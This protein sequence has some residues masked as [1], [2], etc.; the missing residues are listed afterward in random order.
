MARTIPADEFR[1]WLT[2]TEA[3]RRLAEF[4]IS[5]AQGWIFRRLREGLIRAA[6]GHVRQDE[7]PP[8]NY[9]LFAP[10]DFREWA[11]QIDTS[12]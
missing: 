8:Q 9:L 5:D 7:F 3:L 10:S 2:P 6:A 4:S 12:F 1:R 11:Y